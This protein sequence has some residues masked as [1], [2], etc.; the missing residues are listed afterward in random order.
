MDPVVTE[1]DF[2]GQ[3]GPR[4]I[5]REI[6][7]QSIIQGG[8]NIV[9]SDIITHVLTNPDQV[10]LECDSFA[11]NPLKAQT[12]MVASLVESFL[13]STGN[14]RLASVIG[15]SRPNQSRIIAPGMNEDIPNRDDVWSNVRNDVSKADKLDATV[16]QSSTDEWN[17]ASSRIEEG[18]PESIFRK[19]VKQFDSSERINLANSL[20]VQTP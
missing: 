3:G 20:S 16:E 5:S 15:A 17:M 8:G 2:I 10:S 13:K 19:V 9:G 11:F 6:H 1:F 7:T 12:L 18:T 4:A 14:V